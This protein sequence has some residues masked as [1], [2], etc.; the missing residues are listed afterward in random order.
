MKTTVA[1]LK[2]LCINFMVMSLMFVG[3]SSAE[4]DFETCVGM[5]LFNEG[6]GDCRRRFLWDGQ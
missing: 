1:R 2:L 4:I 3:I 6:S 5:W